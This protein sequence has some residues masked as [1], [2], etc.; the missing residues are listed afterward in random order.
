MKDNF[1]NNYILPIIRVINVILLVIFGLALI[2]SS[3]L[4]DK[5][6]IEVNGYVWLIVFGVSPLL[7]SI[8]KYVIES[9]HEFYEWDKKERG[10]KKSF[11]A[12]LTFV[13]F[14]F[15]YLS[16]FILAIT[17]HD[18]KYKEFRD[19]SDPDIF[20]FSIRFIYGI[21]FFLNSIFTVPLHYRIYS[22]YLTIDN[23]SLAKK[24]NNWEWERTSADDVHDFMNGTL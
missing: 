4:K 3:V 7:S 15:T 23:Y 17:L 11:I 16:V 1:F 8:I 14:C 24:P 2:A 12:Q 20:D 19:L 21:A 18:F 10:K 13:V 5:S 22:E 9:K 6:I